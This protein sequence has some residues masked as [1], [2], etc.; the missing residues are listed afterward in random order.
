MKSRILQ[1][2]FLLAGLALTGAA[3]AETAVWKEQQAKLNYFGVTALYT[4]NGLEDKIRQVFR[5]LGARED[6]KVRA[7]GCPY[8]PSEP[9]NLIWVDISFHTLASAEAADGNTVTAEW[10]DV[11]LRPTRL[12]SMGSGDCE[13][14]EMLKPVLE[15]SFTAQQLTVRTQCKPGQV[16]IGD[17]RISGKL[18]DASR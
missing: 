5:Q 2:I 7:T 17:Y 1:S 16:G 6:I 15:K 8:G 10:H 9:T 14:M 18:L 11:D 3:V 4:C 13:V 12:N